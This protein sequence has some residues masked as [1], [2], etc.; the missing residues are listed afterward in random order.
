VLLPKVM[1]HHSEYDLHGKFHTFLDELGDL[2]PS[3]EK[4]LNKFIKV[5]KHGYIQEPDAD[6]HGYL[7]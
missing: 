7:K 6:D 2:Q 4:S 1:M 3:A 5:D